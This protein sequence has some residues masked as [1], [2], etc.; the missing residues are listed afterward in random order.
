MDTMKL[1][2]LTFRRCILLGALAFGCVLSS[3]AAKMST[4]ID[5]RYNSDDAAVKEQ[6]E[7]E[8]RR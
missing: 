7:A 2:F 1:M 5:S 4:M 3:C 8:V 6:H